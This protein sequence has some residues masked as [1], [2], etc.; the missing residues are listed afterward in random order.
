MI[1]KRGQEKRC[2]CLSTWSCRSTRTNVTRPLNEWSI[3]PSFFIHPFPY[4]V[5]LIKTIVY[6]T[7]SKISQL[8][9]A[10]IRIPLGFS[11]FNLVVNWSNNMRKSFN[12]TRNSSNLLNY[13]TKQVILFSVL[14]VAFVSLGGLLPF[15]SLSIVS[16]IDLRS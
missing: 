5:S 14:V 2:Q 9:M 15:Y 13:C 6:F 7:C 1:K 12:L 10:C 16:L 8:M 11:L 4:L 3:W